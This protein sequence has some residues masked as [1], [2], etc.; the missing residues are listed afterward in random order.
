MCRF[1]DNETHLFIVFEAKAPVAFLLTLVRTPLDQI[2]VTCVCVCVCVCVCACGVRSYEYMH[3]IRFYSYML[4][5]RLGLA[6]CRSVCPG[7]ARSLAHLL[8]LLA[9][10]P[11]LLLSRHTLMPPPSTQPANN[12]SWCGTGRWHGVDCG[13]IPAQDHSMSFRAPLR[14]SMLARI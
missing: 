3:A 8:A 10:V 14:I 4:L 7:L 1:Q 9:T 2:R 5:H 6:P 12:N 11:S 13:G